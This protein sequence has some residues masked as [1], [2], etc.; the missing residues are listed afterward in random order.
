[1][2]APHCMVH[3][4]IPAKSPGRFTSTCVL[5]LLRESAASVHNLAHY[6]PYWVDHPTMC[7][8]HNLQQRR[9]PVNIDRKKKRETEKEKLLGLSSSSL[10]LLLIPGTY[11]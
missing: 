3:E 11:F 2:V 9:S 1:M 8:V 4:L 7:N 10:D 5:P 6:C